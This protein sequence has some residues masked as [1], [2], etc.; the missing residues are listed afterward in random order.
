MKLRLPSLLMLALWLLL[1]ALVLPFFDFWRFAPLPD[2]ISDACASALMALSALLLTLRR[3]RGELEIHPIELCLWLLALV[4]A[5]EQLLLHPPYMQTG[6]LAI[7]TL[8][9]A[10]FS[11][12][13]I[14]QSVQEYGRD[15]VLAALA[16][17]LLIGALVQSCLGLVQMLGLAPLAR[18]YVIFALN[19]PTSL[20]GNIGQRNQFGHYLGWG[21]VSACYLASTGRLRGWLFYS[22][23]VV[24]ALM[25]TWSASR[26]VI[27]YGLG[28]AAIAWIWLRRGKGDPAVVAWARAMAIAA[29]AIAFTQLFVDQIDHVLQAAGLPIHSGS[30]AQRIMDAGFGARRRIEWHKAW[31]VFL[32]HP[33]LGMGWG[34]FAAQSV[35]LEATGLFGHVVEDGLFTHAHDLVLHLLAE[36][37]L[38]GT[39]VVVG[40]IV[41]CVLSLFKRSALGPASGCVLALAMITIGHSLFEYPLWYVPFLLGFT[42]ILA[43]SPAT[44]MPFP[45]R[46]WLRV[47]VAGGLGI[48]SLCFVVNGY[49]IF[50]QLVNN[51]APTTSQTENQQRVA[52][53]LHVGKNPLW[54]YESD[55]LL[56]Y[57]L[58]ATPDHLADKRQLFERLA[59][60]RPYHIILVKLA[61]LQAYDG[62]IETAKL[63]LRRAIAVYPNW[64]AS[65]ADLLRP[66]KGAQLRELKALADAASGVYKQK[67]SE[68]VASWASAPLGQPHL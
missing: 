39:V 33:V 51:S 66:Y 41:W 44:L 25:M 7:G 23:T 11:A 27:A 5:V 46:R 38:L 52:K 62:D 10:A 31:A 19:D 30:G 50:W 45:L 20:L 32:E 8:S 12:G 35:H 54:M 14:R 15:K 61:I 9:L 63:N 18:G 34:S 13:A 57:F 56:S 42:I 36:T 1:A 17:A 64:T 48:A 55:F 60:Y 68:Y 2:W 26:L 40:G 47:G 16:S 4:V 3:P 65:I 37:G 53:L 49:F 22:C 59:R 43:L 58:F 29:L 67:G 21:L 24:L 6:V 28:I